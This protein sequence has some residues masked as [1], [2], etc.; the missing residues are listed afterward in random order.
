MLNIVYYNKNTDQ[1]VTLL[2]DS[3]AQIPYHIAANCPLPFEEKQ[4][5]TVFGFPWHV[6][7][8]SEF[9]VGNLSP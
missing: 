4:R 5:D 1:A 7:H 9:L 6:V 2:T 3:V 8:G